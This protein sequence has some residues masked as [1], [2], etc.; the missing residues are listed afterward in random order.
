MLRDLVKRWANHKVVVK[1]VSHFFHYIAR[2][3]IARRNIP[4]LDEVGL[5]CIQDL[6]YDALKHKAKHAVFDLIY[7]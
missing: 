2:Y 6:V 7:K 1:W 4:G 3:H 5:A